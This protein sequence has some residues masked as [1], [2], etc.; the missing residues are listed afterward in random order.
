MGK[1]RE[2]TILYTY[3]VPNIVLQYLQEMEG[4]SVVPEVRAKAKRWEVYGS[5]FHSENGKLIS[6]ILIVQQ[7]VTGDVKLSFTG[8]FWTEAE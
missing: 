5:M 3:G 1:Q 2:T 7:T 8:D 4:L 6:A